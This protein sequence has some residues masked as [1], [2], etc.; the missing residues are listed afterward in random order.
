MGHNAPDT[1]VNHAEAPG[2]SQHGRHERYHE[3]NNII[4]V[5]AY[6]K[7]L[8]QNTSRSEMSYTDRFVEFLYL[9]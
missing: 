6:L 7:H 4:I 3:T 8:I 1:I 9:P 5:Q 2:A